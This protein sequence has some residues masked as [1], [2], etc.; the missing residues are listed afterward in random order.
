MDGRP[1]AFPGQ[2]RTLT[3]LAENPDELSRVRRIA[4]SSTEYIDN[5]S[6]PL[7][8]AARRGEASARSIATTED[9]GA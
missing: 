9:G 2:V 4:R 7:V 8:N 3:H 6:V 5:Y 1:A